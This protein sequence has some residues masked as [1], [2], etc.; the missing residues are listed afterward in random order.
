MEMD[1][2][3]REVQAAMQLFKQLNSNT[4]DVKSNKVDT[5]SNSSS[6][7]SNSNSNSNHQPVKVHTH[8]QM[9]KKKNIKYFFSSL[10][11]QETRSYQQSKQCHFFKR[12]SFPCKFS[13]KYGRLLMSTRTTT[14][15]RMSF[16][17]HSI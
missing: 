16:V 11:K 4:M 8:C 5:S 6:N 13:N 12:V 14:C 15:R 17:L 7:S 9:I 10:I 1:V 2:T 3:T